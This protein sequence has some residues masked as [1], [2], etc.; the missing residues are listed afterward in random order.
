MTVHRAIRACLSRRAAPA[1]RPSPKPAGKAAQRGS[2][3][4]EMALLAP[5]LLLVL[6]GVIEMGLLFFTNLTMQYAVREG[7]RYAV[8]GLSDADPATADQQRYRAVMQKIKD[9]SMGMYAKVS[10]VVTVNKTTYASSSA[11]TSNMFGGPGDIVVLQL[12]CYWALGTP[13]LAVFFP[14]GTYHFTVAATMRNE[15]F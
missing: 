15:S 2:A 11:Y 9:S 4:V 14:K 10:P 1:A 12:D 6:I 3:I 13:L 8:T 7:A 5:V